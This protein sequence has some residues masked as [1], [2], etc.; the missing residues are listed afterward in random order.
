MSFYL[1]YL[2]KWP[3]YFLVQKDPNDTIMGYSESNTQA[4]SYASF[5]SLSGPKL[6]SKPSTI[7]FGLLFYLQLWARRKAKALIGTDT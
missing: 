7:L 5:A 2:S 4:V 1:Q 6:S 3:D